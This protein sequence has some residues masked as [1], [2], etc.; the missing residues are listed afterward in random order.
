M[1]TCVFRRHVAFC[2][3]TQIGA[4]NVGGEM[5]GDKEWSFNG[6][7]NYVIMAEFGRMIPESEAWCFGI[8]WSSIHAL[9]RACVRVC[10]CVCV[11]A[12]ACMCGCACACL[13]ARVRVCEICIQ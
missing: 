1:Y 7:I 11:H 13:C 12:C 6:V 2:L 3:I 8:D 5:C 9:V 4:A 10:A